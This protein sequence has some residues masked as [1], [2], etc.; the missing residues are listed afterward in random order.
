MYKNTNLSQLG[1]EMEQNFT[2]EAF[3]YTLAKILFSRDERLE[4][5]FAD[6]N[7]SHSSKNKRIPFD[8]ERVKILKS[9]L[10]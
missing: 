10:F 8:L 4:G 2:R 7:N 3:A 5:W 6:V 1:R 9:N